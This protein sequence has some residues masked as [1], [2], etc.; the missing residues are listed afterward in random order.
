MGFPSCLRSPMLSERYRDGVRLWAP[1]KVNLHLEVLAKRSDG[2]HE[3][4]TLMVAV[5]LY[6]TLEFGEEERHNVWAGRC[7]SCCSVRRL[8][9]RPPTPTAAC[10]SRSRR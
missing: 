10:R 9:W 6:D 5:S 1:A 4:E 3:L 8:D 2:Y 7:G